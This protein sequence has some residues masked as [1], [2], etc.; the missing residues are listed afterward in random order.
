MIRVTPMS[1]DFFY[2]DPE[3]IC[4]YP[5]ASGVEDRWFVEEENE[6]ASGK[7][8]MPKSGEVIYAY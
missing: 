7:S 4:D 8:T 5:N 2:W 1:E 6:R 3:A